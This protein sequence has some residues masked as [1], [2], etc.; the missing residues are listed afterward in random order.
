MVS[1]T[2]VRI[3]S[4]SSVGTFE[5]N[6]LLAGGLHR[7]ATHTH[8]LSRTRI[9]VAESAIWMPLYVSPAECQNQ[10]RQEIFLPSCSTSYL[11]L[12]P[13]SFLSSH[14]SQYSSY[15]AANL[16]WRSVTTLLWW[17]TQFFFHKHNTQNIK[18]CT[19]AIIQAL[20]KNNS[21]KSSSKC[22]RTLENEVSVPIFR[23][24]CASCCGFPIC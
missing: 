12:S 6:L 23:Q 21:K 19:S 20:N 7:P 4:A 16:L 18:Q 5:H 9:H 15:P 1:W 11:H 22:P 24:C 2:D 8:T 3:Y 14:P 17:T 10:H 13:A